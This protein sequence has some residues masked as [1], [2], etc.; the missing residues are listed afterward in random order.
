MSDISRRK[1]L[2]IQQAADILGVH[3]NTL[4]NMDNRGELKAIRF[5]ARGDRRY[6]KS[7]INKYLKKLRNR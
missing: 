2:T 1:L 5:G 6:L 4:R 3:P 7:D